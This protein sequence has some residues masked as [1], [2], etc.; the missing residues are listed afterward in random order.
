MY[1]DHYVTANK[2]EEEMGSPLRGKKE[3]QLAQKRPNKSISYIFNFFIINEPLK[4]YDV[5]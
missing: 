3:K 1:V 2:F 4:K 5:K